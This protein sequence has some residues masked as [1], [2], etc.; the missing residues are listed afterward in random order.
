MT[1]FTYYTL[2]WTELCHAVMVVSQSS[3]L[4]VLRRFNIHYTTKVKDIKY[5]QFFCVSAYICYACHSAYMHYIKKLR[6][7]NI[8]NFFFCVVYIGNPHKEADIVLYTHRHIFG[9][10]TI[11]YTQGLTSIYIS[12]FLKAWHFKYFGCIN[13]GFLLLYAP[14]G[15]NIIM[16]CLDVCFLNT[17]FCRVH[18]YRTFWKLKLKGILITKVETIN[19]LCNTCKL[20]AVASQ[21]DIFQANKV[22]CSMHF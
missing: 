22:L 3:S 1:S 18:V 4:T 17:A 19:L 9:K 2:K 14:R 12:Q 11:K 16:Q 5:P 15:V 21:S 13:Q 8:L 20:L 10:C 6:I 7:F